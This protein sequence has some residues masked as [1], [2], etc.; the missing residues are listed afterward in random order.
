M[1]ES[2]GLKEQ[3][4]MKASKKPAP[5]QFSNNENS[6]FYF[7]RVTEARDQRGGFLS[8]FDDLSYEGD[9][10]LNQ[11]ARNSYLRKKMNDDE[12]RIVTGTTEKKIETVVNE[13]LLL[14][15]QPEITAY[16]NNGLEIEDLGQEIGDIIK[17]TNEIEHDDDV[18]QEAV[19]ELVSQRAVFVEEVWIDKVDPKN[20]KKRIQRAEKRLINGLQMFLG[21]ITIPAYRF[22][23]QPYIIKYERMTYKEAK[24]YYG[25]WENWKY[26]VPGPANMDKYGINYKW[27]F[28]TTQKNEVEIIH[29]MS[30]ADNEYMIIIQDVM[31]ME[32]SPL[33]WNYEGYNISMTTLKS[34]S[35]DFAYGKPLTASAKTL[36]ALE[37]EM[38]RNLVRKFRQAIEPPIG[39]SVG[40]IFSKDMWSPASI[41][42]GVSKNDF[43]R[44]IE[45]DGVTNSEFAM[46][47]LITRKAE[48]FV[49]SSMVN[50]T[51]SKKVPTATQIQEQQKQAA[52]LLGLAVYAIMR[53]KRNLTQMRINSV[54]TDYLEPIGKKYD[55]Q[56]QKIKNTHHT[57]S[58]KEGT[59]ENG[60]KG[61]KVISLMDRSLT[62][63]E[64]KAILDY[65]KEQEQAGHPIR[66]KT[67][68]VNLLSKFPIL[69]NVNV[70]SQDRDSTALN[71]AMFTDQ[72]N[73]ANTVSQLTQRPL[74][75]D[76]WIERFETTWKAKDS[77]QKQAPTQLG[78]GQQGN[79]VQGQAQ[80]LL[81]KIGELGGGVASKL[82]PDGPQKPSLNTM[83]QV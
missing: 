80:D 45:H 76:T 34:L 25:E 47:D 61:K 56:T 36:Q 62:D 46:F 77:F 37:N 7:N 67:I 11:Q 17:R 26:V 3:K 82:A 71:K 59:F 72:I 69:W 54:L 14:N 49:G 42:Q 6:Q 18:W 24:T 32:P 39:V 15:L 66:I 2:I 13:L 64:E 50:N 83:S 65:E 21:D 53:L 5:Y 40:K 27:R 4:E 19:L 41:S 23:D 28:G 68:N 10:V 20:K 35:T 38:I 30:A 51:T 9:Y 52:K 78:G 58:I 55:P 48:E 31:M 81:S 63:M 29:Y 75:P 60:Q 79:G 43:S 57:F 12:V 73:Q 74:N 16:D 1:E 33:P 70:T 44:L 8:Y 22:N